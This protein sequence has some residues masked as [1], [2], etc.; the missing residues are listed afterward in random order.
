[1][2]N[3]TAPNNPLP[4]GHLN[5]TMLVRFSF[6][7][8]LKWMAHPVSAGLHKLARKRLRSTP[9]PSLFS[10]LCPQMS[11]QSEQDVTSLRACS[12]LPQSIWIERLRGF[13]SSVS[14]NL[15]QSVSI[16][17]NP[18]GLKI[19]EQALNVRSPNWFWE[20]GLS[21]GLISITNGLKLILYAIFELTKGGRRE[22]FKKIE[23]EQPKFNLPCK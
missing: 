4:K 22:G 23:R 6:Q 3:R 16:S 20:Q 12:V 2:I 14:Q 11:D 13:Q 19:T 18:Y 10:L 15:S 17:F 1:L 8:L 9:I 7:G 5:L 21:F